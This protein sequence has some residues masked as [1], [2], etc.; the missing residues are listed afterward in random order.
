MFGSELSIGFNMGR[1][2]D[3][4]RCSDGGGDFEFSFG[5]VHRVLVRLAG[6]LEPAVDVNGCWNGQS[7]IVD[8]F[9]NIGDASA[10]FN[11]SV[12]VVMPEFDADVSGL[13]GDLDLLKNRDWFDRA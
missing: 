9:P 12:D 1:A 2:G 7:G 13:R 5:F 10:G 11:M 3:T 4:V 6:W 8:G